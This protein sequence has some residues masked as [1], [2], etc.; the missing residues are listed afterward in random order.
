MQCG[1]AAQD[2]RLKADYLN[3]KTAIIKTLNFLTYITRTP[4]SSSIKGHQVVSLLWP[5][6]SPSFSFILPCN[7]PA[8][9][10]LSRQQNLEHHISWIPC[11]EKL[12]FAKT[13]NMSGGLQDRSCMLVWLKVLK[14]ACNFVGLFHVMWRLGVHT[15]DK[16][17]L[18]FS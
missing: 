6:S 11:A 14:I 16:F 12:I 7:L 17:S 1:C 13:R 18:K 3:F 8:R 15:V 10:K 5:F 2:E 9:E 4:N